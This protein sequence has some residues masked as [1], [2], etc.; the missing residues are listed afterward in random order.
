MAE[1]STIVRNTCRAMLPGASGST[2]DVVTTANP[3]QQ[4]ALDF[5]Q[6]ITV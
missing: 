3:K 5:F 2:F 4:R 1:L 6:T